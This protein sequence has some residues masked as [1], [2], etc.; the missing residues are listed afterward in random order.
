MDYPQEEYRH[1]ENKFS[2][3]A[4]NNI[5]DFSRNYQNIINEGS[6][7]L[8]PSLGNFPAEREHPQRF[9]TRVIQ[10]SHDYDRMAN[11][12]H[13]H[14]NIPNTNSLYYKSLTLQNYSQYNNR[15]SSFQNENNIVGNNPYQQ[16]YNNGHNGIYPEAH[17]SN[18]PQGQPYDEK[19]YYTN[20]VSQ[21]ER[22]A[23]P[24]KGY[25]TI[26]T[27]NKDEGLKSKAKLPDKISQKENFTFGGLGPNFSVD[28]LNKLY[29]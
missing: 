19:G 21:P 8:Q 28:W 9:P 2:K 3:N 7:P 20:K 11:T 25:Y 14:S 29:H 24:V 26:H 12:D 13:F 5:L 1:P 17:T 15:P 4:Q 6:R 10:S 27:K 16:V 18:F 22:D 23:I